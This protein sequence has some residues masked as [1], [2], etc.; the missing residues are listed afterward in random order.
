MLIARFPSDSMA[1]LLHKTMSIQYCKA[2]TA[3]CDIYPDTEDLSY[4]R[5]MAC[6]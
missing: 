2:L 6:W 3:D 5:D 4:R 1:F